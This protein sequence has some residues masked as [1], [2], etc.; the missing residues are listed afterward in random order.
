VVVIVPAQGSDDLVRA[1]V[2]EEGAAGHEDDL[3]HVG[4]TSLSTM[5]AG[6]MNSSLLRSD[7]VAIRR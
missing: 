2:A 4:A 5:A 3:D 6:R 7:P 1:L